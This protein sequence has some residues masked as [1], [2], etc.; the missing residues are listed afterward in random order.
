MVYLF[1][2]HFDCILVVDVVALIQFVQSFLQ[3]VPVLHDALL[4]LAPAFLSLL[5]CP[6]QCLLLLHQDG[7]LLIAL[8]EGLLEQPQL[9]LGSF[10]LCLLRLLEFCNIAQTL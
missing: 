5:S 9:D 2:Q 4:A 10:E 1:L 7:L 8:V 6:C 3:F